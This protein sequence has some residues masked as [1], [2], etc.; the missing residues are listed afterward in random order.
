MA[1]SGNAFAEMLKSPG[2]ASQQPGKARR[3]VR[4]IAGAPIAPALP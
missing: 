2:K 3:V 4:A 1:Y